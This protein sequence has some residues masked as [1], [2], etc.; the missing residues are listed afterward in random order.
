MGKR[1][2]GEGTI[3]QR[4]DGRWVSRLGM[5]NGKPWE[6]YSATAEEANEKLL[7]A[8]YARSRGVPVVFERQ[9][10]ERFLTRWLRDVVKPGTRPRTFQAYETAVRLHIV[11]EL[12]RLN[13]QQ[14]SSEHVQ[15]LISRKREENALSAKSIRAVRGTLARALKW[16]LEIG[17]VARNVATLTRLPRIPD[18]E[19]RFLNDD[20]ARRIIAAVK[21]TRY[22]A[23]YVTALNLGLRRG[24][25]C[26][27]Q[28]D[29]LDLDRGTLR[30]NASLQRMDGALRVAEP[31]TPQSNR[32]LTLPKNVIVALRVHKSRQAQERLA[33]GPKWRDGGWVF[34][35][36][37][38]TAFEP[39][40]LDRHFSQLLKNAGL[41]HLPFKNLRH[42]CA[43]LLLSEG[44]DLRVI[45]EILGHSSIATTAKFYAAVTPKRMRAAADK[46]DAIL[47]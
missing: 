1:T 47:G 38:G 28:W 23:M 40:N 9:T 41:P 17:A 20:E 32:V 36:N 2:S 25:L 13:L 12:G 42:S 46:M 7:K 34:C 18:H 31:K 37:R 35:S 5:E 33:S 29:S 4:K 30:V 45:Q 11:P 3:F 24:E 43:S 22:A 6:A 26:A 39:R 21:G 44:E 27:L 15:E 19:I 8:R 16:G 10:V 14:L